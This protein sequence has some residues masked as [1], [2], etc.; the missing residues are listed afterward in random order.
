MSKKRAIEICKNLEQTIGKM[1]KT[2]HL[3]HKNEMF[4]LPRA[5]KKSLEKIK[6]RLKNKY[7]LK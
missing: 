4:E 7:N 1:P 5:R 2:N 6:V 3:G